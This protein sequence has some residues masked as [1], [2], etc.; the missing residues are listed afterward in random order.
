MQP[1][2]YQLKDG[3]VL[4]I[5]DVTAEDARAVLDY[6]ECISAESDFLT[7]GLG[8]LEMTE[9]E[10]RDY[11][12]KCLEADNQLYILG[13]MNETITGT[14]HLAAGHR[15]RIRHTGELGMSVRKQYWNLGI[16]SLILDALID[17]A[18][19]TEIIKK[20]NLRVRTDNKSAIAL[21]RHKGFVTEGRIRKEIFLN[22]TYFDQYWM[23]LEL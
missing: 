16:G 9:A 4:V 23:G 13:L 7:F 3:R 15:P 5:R 19:Q 18:R 2:Q 21:Y 17:W 12:H 22:G 6:L 14:L 20:I 11:L 10:E 8:Q 1:R